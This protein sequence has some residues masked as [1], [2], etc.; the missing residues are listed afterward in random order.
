[1]PDGA[2]SI[3][4]RAAQHDSGLP[5]CGH[6]DVSFVKRGNRTRMTVRK[7]EPPWRVIR[8]FDNAESQAVLHLHNVSGGILSGDSLYLSI[9]AGPG[10]C[11]QITSVGATKIHRARCNSSPSKVCTSIRVGDGAMLEYLPDATIPFGGSRFH[12]CAVVTLGSNAGLVWWE[13]LSAGR[14][15]KGEEFEFEV[16]SS[17]CV[18]RSENRPL[19]LERYS[20]RPRTHNLCSVS[21]WSRFRYTATLYVCRTGVG[22]KEWI[23]LERHLNDLAFSM[24]S[25]MARWGVS[26]LIADGLVIRGLALEAHHIFM[27]LYEFWAHAKQDV[28]GKPAIPPR[29]IN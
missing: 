14:V 13:I 19:A 4:R 7:Q 25:E 10:T 27:G 3:I 12:Q 17:D 23:G 21:R 16:F 29:K 24:S 1:M 28:W 6:L 5:L 18:I 20:L 26:A 15:A 8:A 2:L 9:E 22:Q 11:V